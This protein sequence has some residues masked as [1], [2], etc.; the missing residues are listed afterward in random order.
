MK[1]NLISQWGWLME[2]YNTDESEMLEFLVGARLVTADDTGFE[3]V[4]PDD[5]RYRFNFEEYERTDYRYYRRHRFRQIFCRES[6]SA[7]L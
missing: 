2:I 5:K 6:D 1:P 7:V 3:V 4:A